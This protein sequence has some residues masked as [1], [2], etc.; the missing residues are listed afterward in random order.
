MIA[1]DTNVLVRFLTGDDPDQ[2]ADAAALLQGL[3]PE[4]PGF[5]ARE[6]ALELVWVLSCGYRLSRKRIAELLEELLETR[7]LVFE[8]AVDVAHAAAEYGRGG[9]GFADRM[10]VA[11]ARRAGALP[12]F[13]F[14][15][16]LAR[17]QGACEVRRTRGGS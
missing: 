17:I 15:G 5:V 2:Q 7:G 11:A 10:I 9:P 3:T 12:L 6:V 1:L 4:N 16:D 14:D 13:T 8:D